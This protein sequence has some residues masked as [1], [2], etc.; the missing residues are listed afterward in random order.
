MRSPLLWLA[1]ACHLF[2]ATG[3][4][5]LTPSFEAPDENDHFYYAFH[6]A[7]AGHLP[8]SPGI[9]AARG[10]APTEGA[11]LAHHPPLYYA[12]LAAYLCASQQTDTVFSP[13]TNPR[14]GDP[15]HASQH[16][17][18]LHGADDSRPWT[19]G[20]LVLLGLRWLSVL[21]GLG[22]ILCV[23]WL[24]HVSYPEQPRVAD[25]AALL[26]SCLP[27]WSF[28]HG[29]LN[30]DSLATLL[31]SASLTMLVL[32]ARSERLTARTAIGTGVLLGLALLTK[33]TTLFLLPLA[34]IVFATAVSREMRAGHG[35]RAAL[36]TMGAVAAV[37]A[38]CGWMF[39]R[40]ASLYGD[41]LA[42]SAHDAAFAS[43]KI[44]E[45]LVWPW[46][47][48]GFL[49]QVS[50]SLLGRFGWFHLEP[51]RALVWAGAILTVCACGGFA[52]L[53][54]DRTARPRPLWLLAA[55]CLLVFAGTAHFN[56]TAPQPQG[57][58]LF[59]A[60]APAAV[61]FAAGLLRFLQ[62][63]RLQRVGKAL[64]ALPPVLGAVVLFGWFAPA[65]DPALAPGPDHHA[66]MVGG[67]LADAPVPGIA[68]KEPLPQLPA[69]VAPTLKWSDPSA[70]PDA[71]YSLYAGD[72][73][74]RVWLA[75]Y[76]W[77]AIEMRGGE[78]IIDERAWPFL[79][80]DRDVFLVLRRVPNWRKGERLA[81]MPA[82]A[83][84]PFRRE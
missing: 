7:N 40:N 11:N 46:L 76:E 75:A 4:V 36:L 28:L 57:R 15:T 20:H 8:L 66:S 12:L 16:L 21:F 6:L 38:L 31:A 25:A 10:L 48:S 63:I 71:F 82:S 81:D 50:S 19:E 80:T 39:W 26:V 59:P 53:L 44:P 14:F 56:M 30:S 18:F 13:R 29:V 62:M 23:H 64:C 79:P 45:S 51:H 84:L 74:G 3:Y 65:F 24:G 27:M 34:A 58:L 9:V 69:R 33:N 47:W 77:G 17:H 52:R 5:I 54:F 32:V 68:W 73:D 43:S 42:M 83:P 22:S 1:L 35:P 55:A 49:P 67:V 60:V 78:A 41:P 72:A 70:G 61:V 37:F 2:L